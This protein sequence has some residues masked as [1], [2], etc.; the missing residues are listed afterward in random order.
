MFELHVFPRELWPAFSAA[1]HGFLIWE[2]YLIF[3]ARLSMVGMERLPAI[4]RTA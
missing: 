3:W 1:V 2:P 4:G